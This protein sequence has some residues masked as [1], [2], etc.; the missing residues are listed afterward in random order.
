MIR[1]LLRVA[2]PL[3]ASVALMTMISSPSGDTMLTVNGLLAAAALGFV[4]IGLWRV[5]EFVV[6]TSRD[7]AADRISDRTPED[8]RTVEMI[9]AHELAHA[10]AIHSAGWHVEQVRADLSGGL[11]R[12]RLDPSEAGG[13]GHIAVK[14]AGTW[15]VTDREQMD[16]HHDSDEA[17]ALVL[18]LRRS[19]ATGE[20]VAGVLDEAA[21]M[22][23]YWLEPYRD[24]LGP[25]AAALVAEHGRRGRLWIT[26]DAA[27]AALDLKNPAV[28]ESKTDTSTVTE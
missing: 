15:S 27:L 24:R 18:A 19:V 21:A 13:I 5:A 20:P 9:V 26:G 23:R 11:C 25:A 14:L 22:A 6:D 12:G 10:V 7:H 17:H 3:A 4:A 2:L 1:Q 16:M 28:P 8:L